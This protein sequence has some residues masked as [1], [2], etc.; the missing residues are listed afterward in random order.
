MIDNNVEYI[1]CAAIH[2]KTEDT[3]PHQPVN[4]EK[5]MVVCGRRH[6]NCFVI[7]SNLDSDFFNVKDKKQGFMTSKD[8]FV[9]RTEAGKIA[10]GA[11]Q[12]KKMTDTLMSED[13]Y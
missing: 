7:I 10:F 8:R 5:G 4:I 9:D 6:H 3:F 13:I 11:G 1:I 12:I 2:L